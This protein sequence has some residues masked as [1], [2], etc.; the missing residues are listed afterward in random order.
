M[1]SVPLDE[2]SDNERSGS[3]CQSKVCGDRIKGID[4]GDAVAAWLSVNLGRHG[5][6]LVRQLNEDGRAGKGDIRFLHPVILTCLYDRNNVFFD[7]C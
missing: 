4:C 3:L 1:V 5:I 7:R 6:R 2:T